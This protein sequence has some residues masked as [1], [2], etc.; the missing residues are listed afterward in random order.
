ML[1]I[2]VAITVAIVEGAGGGEA[3]Q[4]IVPQLQDLPDRR[5]RGSLAGCA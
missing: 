4:P 3:S 1:P 5:G 2:T